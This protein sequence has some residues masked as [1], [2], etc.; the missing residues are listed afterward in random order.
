MACANPGGSAPA[1]LL[2]DLARAAPTP[3]IAARLS[4]AT[5]PADCRDTIASFASIATASCAV[6]SAPRHDP[7]LVRRTAAALRDA[8]RPDALHAAALAELL[9]PGDPGISLERSIS[10]L[11]KAARGDA[12]ADRLSDLAAVHLIRAE[13]LQSPRDLL[14]AIEVAE[15]A[16]EL[17]PRHQAALW[18]L[19]LALERY[20]LVEAARGWDAYLEVDSVSNWANE[21][22]R[23]R[24]GSTIDTVVRVPDLTVCDSPN[25]KS[26]STQALHGFAW[27]VVLGAWGRAVTTGDT[28]G[29]NE[30]LHCARRVAD[31]IIARGGD[32]GVRDAI[33]SIDRVAGDTDRTRR[34]ALAHR[35][36]SEGRA[37]YDSAQYAP[38]DSTFARAVA[39]AGD[40]PR[41]R[42]WATAFGGATDTYLG[43]F[44]EATRTFRSLLARTDATRHPSL[45][46]RTRWMLGT[47]LLRDGR[48]LEAIAQYAIAESL[49][50]RAGEVE[51]GGTVQYLKGEALYHLGRGDETYVMLLRAL[52]TLAPYRASVR[53]HNL[54]FVTSSAASADG[55]PR[56]A[57]R[58]EKEGV[59]VAARIP[60]PMYEVEARLNYA[61]LLTA[62]GRLRE[63]RAQLDLIRPLLP[64]LAPGIPRRLYTASLDLAELSI[65]GGSA[66][67][68]ERA[69]DSL[70]AVFRESR[71]HV[72]LVSAHLMRAGLRLSTHRLDA[73]TADLDSAFSLLAA[74][75]SDFVANPLHAALVDSTRR[76]RDG[77]V[78]RLASTGRSRDALAYL[79]RSRATLTPY[80]RQM[81]I[82]PETG[83]TAVTLTQI[84]DTLLAWTA[85]AGTVTLSRRVVAAADLAATIRRTR[86]EMELGSTDSSARQGLA[87]LHEWIIAPIA[88]RLGRPQ[89]SLTIV[90]DGELGTV[91]FA[92]LYDARRGEYLV[93]RFTIRSGEGGTP[94]RRTWPTNGRALVVGDPAFDRRVVRGLSRL[95]GAAEEAR[96][97]SRIYER[98][99]LLLDG[100]ATA[101]ALLQAAGESA[102]LHVAGHALLDEMRPERSALVLSGADGR[103]T[104]SAE[105]IAGTN[106]RAMRLVVLSACHSATSVPAR[107]SG[108][109]GLAAAFLQAGVGGVV[110]GLWRLDDETTRELMVRFHRAYRRDG[111]AA[112]ALRDAQVGMLTSGRRELSAPGAWAG[113]VYV[114][115]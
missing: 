64:R 63:A 43:R 102:V 104:L 21:A 65:G 90:A 97:V 25:V 99:H 1:V 13:R 26:W 9:W 28:E 107:P 80:A 39:E 23:R 6:S 113:V 95:R 22:R 91:P 62:R 115:N 71:N 77:V 45:A 69:L 53:L 5:A 54:L 2:R 31:A 29:A 105:T 78:M 58:L 85:R 81:P 96:Q 38:A 18:N 11:R 47:T 93:Q 72:R 46:G 76:V 49:F 48:R 87:R 17:A 41:L 88:A 59:A 111:D 114:G 94:V 75:R 109:A 10:Y 30:R 8:P 34:L 7:E 66:Q 44:P 82:V 16:L 14:E 103:G 112:R 92:A 55:L 98:A 19:A 32:A 74:Q 20:G 33:G 68:R 79:H 101:E 56:A 89:Q 4:I 84:G 27:D 106:L 52:R 37:R 40:S 86:D 73:A 42:D 15:Q 50:S 24:R 51:H 60:R 67:E 83:T 108:L 35:S 100:A 57:L 70:T 12:R 61:G 3:P 36:F 110:G